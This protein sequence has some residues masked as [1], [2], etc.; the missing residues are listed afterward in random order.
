M[1]SNTQLSPG[2]RWGGGGGVIYG[3]GN[4][5]YRFNVFTPAPYVFGNL[6]VI[7]LLPTNAAVASSLSLPSL[8][9]FL[10]R[11]CVVALARQ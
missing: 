4:L 9:C 6:H 3:V 11:R 7:F 2:A 10:L 1:Y 5:V 8:K